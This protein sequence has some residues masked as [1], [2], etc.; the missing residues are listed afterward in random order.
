MFILTGYKNV[1]LFINSERDIKFNAKIILNSWRNLPFAQCKLDKKAL[2]TK[3]DT[4]F[5]LQK[6]FLR[7]DCFTKTKSLLFQLNQTYKLRKRF[8]FL[9]LFFF[10]FLSV[11]N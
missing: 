3:C 5:V 8:F 1:F 9:L 2:D 11:V 4:K 6:V 10:F 7:K